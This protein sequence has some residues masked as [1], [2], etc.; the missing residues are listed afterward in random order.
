[1]RETLRGGQITFHGPGQLV[2]YPILDLKNV[3]SDKWPKGLS[4]RCY[5]NVL[6]EATINTLKT[7]G[8]VGFRTDNPGVWVD[9]DRKIAA[10]GLHL[11]RNITNYGVGLNIRTDLRYFDRIVACG[12]EGKKTTSI[13]KELFDDL[14]KDAW[15]QLPK[16]RREGRSMKEYLQICEEMDLTKVST[17]WGKEFVDLVWGEKNIYKHQT[18]SSHMAVA[19]FLDNGEGNWVERGEE[20]KN[21]WEEHR[22]RALNVE[23]PHFRELEVGTDPST[24][25]DGE[26]LG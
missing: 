13:R 26:R 8:I 24:K 11:R 25:P 10:L 19:Q 14:D 12:L 2:I 16:N 18:V 15:I 4:A 22:E 21:E 5:V 7:F 9:E 3:Q 23:I 17:V 20:V 1:M 6:E